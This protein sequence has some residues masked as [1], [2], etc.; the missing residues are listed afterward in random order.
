MSYKRAPLL[1]I[2]L[3]NQSYGSIPRRAIPKAKEI[4]QDSGK[5]KP[6]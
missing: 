5:N 3:V 6:H 1:G 2:D 4:K